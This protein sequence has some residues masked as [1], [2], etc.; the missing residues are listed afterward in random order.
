MDGRSG[1][2]QGSVHGPNGGVALALAC[3]L[4]GLV[5]SAREGDPSWI[6]KS[7]VL[8]SSSSKVHLISIPNR[9]P[10]KAGLPPAR[11]LTCGIR[12]HSL[13]AEKYF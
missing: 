6:L 9:P 12:T 1:S 3:N 10:A 5:S 11:Y 2:G 8:L 7:K 13:L 4:W